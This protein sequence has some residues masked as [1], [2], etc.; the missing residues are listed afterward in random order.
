M[1]KEKEFYEIFSKF[2]KIVS[3]KLETYN[4]ITNIGDQTV[5]TPTSR[6]FGYVCYEDQEVAKKVKNELNG[7]YLPGYEHWKNPL[8]IEYYLS[9]SQKEVMNN[10]SYENSNY[11]NSN[12]IYNPQMQQQLMSN[13][14]KESKSTSIAAFDLNKYNSC[15]NEESK[16]EY[17]GEVIYD[18][19][20][21]SPLINNIPE[22][23]KVTAKITG[24]ILGI[25]NM[26]EIVRISTDNEALTKNVS[27]ALNLLNNKIDKFISFIKCQNSYDNRKK[28]YSFDYKNTETNLKQ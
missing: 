5:S 13:T 26:E 7:Q 27:D 23:D 14:D 1:I 19:V 25:G 8:T 2:G 15:E 20:F 24:M 21:N 4:L 9:K 6:G 17:L 16:K 12:N 3:A 22:K 18:Q 10:M 11:N 28:N